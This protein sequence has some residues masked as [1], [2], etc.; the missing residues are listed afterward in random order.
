[1]GCNSG[2]PTSWERLTSV[3]PTPIK[4]DPNPLRFTIE[5]VEHG[6]GYVLALVR[7]PDCTNHEG[8]KILLF[9]GVSVAWVRDLVKLDPHFFEGGSIVARF[10]PTPKGL[11]MARTF[12]E[13]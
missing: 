2:K 1:M 3:P 6:N 13:R 11:K 8:L 10:A 9:H 5:A 12:L 4:G 7:Y